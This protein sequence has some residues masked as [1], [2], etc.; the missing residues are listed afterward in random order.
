MMSLMSGDNSVVGEDGGVDN[1]DVVDE[2]VVMV[3]FC[4]WC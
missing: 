2:V 4:L 1:E 3:G